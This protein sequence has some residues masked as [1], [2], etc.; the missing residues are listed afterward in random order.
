MRDATIKDVARL[1]EVSVA[2]VSRVLTGSAP[3]AEPTRRRV[4]AA[5]TSL[6]Y[7]PHAAARSL[8]SRRTGALGVVLPDLY[9]EFFSEFLRGVDTTAQRHGLHLLVSS[10]HHDRAGVASVLRT[11]R[12]RVDGLLV[13]TPDLDADA[14]L[15]HLPA[16]LPVVLVGCAAAAAER[17][18][19]VI[20]NVGGAHA[21]V[22]HLLRLGHRVIGFIGGAGGNAD[23]RSRLDGYRRA[24]LDAGLAPAPALELEG[25]FTE[26][27]GWR[28]AYQL[29]ARPERPTA[30]FAAND[31]MAVG[32]LGAL[33]EAGVAVPGEVALVG[34]DDIP[35]ARYLTPT[36]TTVRVAVDVLGERA[37]QLLLL[38][39]AAERPPPGSPRREVL[40]TTLVVR[41][42]CGAPPLARAATSP[43]L[44]PPVSP[45]SSPLE[46]PR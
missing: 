17:D 41:E 21:A 36:L 42:S 19:L 24:L 20:D 28:A 12:G 44:H 30:I 40:P 3:V 38:R 25:D 15:A 23:A 13:M 27:G 5:A 4:E 6:R 10:S 11:M 26:E 2:T 39:T 1:A 32:A 45:P 33:R 14:L 34:F 8:S 9:G 18:Q 7:A 22:A 29:L 16:R 31:A 37:V 46:I 35:V 43:R